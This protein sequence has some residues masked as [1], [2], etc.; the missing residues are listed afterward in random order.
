LEATNLATIHPSI[1]LVPR[2]YGPFTVTK[3]I[4]L[5]IYQLEIPRYWKIHNVFYASLLTLYNK[6]GI[7]RLNYMEPP[8][9][10]VDNK[11]EQEVDHIIGER[12]Y[13]QWKE[14]QY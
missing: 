6:T 14:L 2:R 12:Y 10:I 1:K 3:T 5:V 7:H 8:P 11:P 4:L 9:D 13:R